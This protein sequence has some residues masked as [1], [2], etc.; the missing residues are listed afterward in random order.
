MA[1]DMQSLLHSAS[2]LVGSAGSAGSAGSGLDMQSL[3]HSSSS[4]AGSAGSGASQVLTAAVGQQRMDQFKH[5]AE[6]RASGVFDMASPLAL[7]LA[8]SQI[9]GGHLMLDMGK[10]MLKADVPGGFTLGDKVLIQGNAQPGM[11]GF[12]VTSVPDGA[13]IYIAE[14]RGCFH[15][16]CCWM[17]TGPTYHVIKG[18]PLTGTDVLLMQS[19]RLCCCTSPEID[20]LT[21]DGELL[22]GVDEHG[23]CC[24]STSTNADVRGTPV[25]RVTGSILDLFC[26][27]S[28]SIMPVG[29]VTAVGQIRHSCGSISIDFPSDARSSDKAAL[30]AASLLWHLRVT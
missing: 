25:Y 30:L 1:L 3:L 29:G 18:N 2:G 6:D 8:A 19:H 7:D 21:P 14:E 5:E 15:C 13:E 17:G 12:R 22:A 4:L 26:C 9:P 23:C 16:C 20:V 11:S 10:R 28:H 24:F 27:G